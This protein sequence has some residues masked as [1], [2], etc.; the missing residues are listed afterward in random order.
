LPEF[1]RLGIE[2]QLVTSAALPI[3]QEYRIWDNL[4][5]VVS[6]DGLQPEHDKRRSPATYARILD[7]IS[8]QTVI[9]HCTVTKQLASNPS[10]LPEFAGFWSSRDEVRKIWFSLY[11][12]Q[13][14]ENS[15][16]RLLR[17][18]RNAALEELL[19]VRRI[20]PKVYQDRDFH[21]RGTRSA[22]ISRAC[23][24]PSFGSCLG[25]RWAVG[26]SAGRNEK[27]R[28]LQETNT[29]FQ[30]PM[31]NENRVLRLCPDA[32]RAVC[33]RPN[34]GPERQHQRGS[35]GFLAGP[36]RTATCAA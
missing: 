24:M 12:P 3:P 8:G 25:K 13:E 34:T 20:F 6:V 18:D 27:I 15:D 23:C 30:Q 1:D 35:S 11:T 9:I 4:H 14:S 31:G 17:E 22:M 10:H 29:E 32:L 16:E 26:R 5:I 33:T 19:A 2:V 36:H 7:N 28:T 21:I